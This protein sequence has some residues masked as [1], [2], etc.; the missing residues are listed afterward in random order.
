MAGTPDMQGPPA[1]PELEPASAEAATKEP[2]LPLGTP[3]PP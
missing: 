3:P 2:E 1:L